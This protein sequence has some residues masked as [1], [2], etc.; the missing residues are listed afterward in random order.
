MK[1]FHARLHRTACPCLPTDHGEIITH[2]LVEELLDEEFVRL[3]RFDGDRF[4]DARDNFEEVALAQDFPSFLPLPVYA[5][6]LT[7]AREKASL[8]E[9]AAS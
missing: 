1:S 6:Y 8:E 3:E 4:E 2:E 7:E 9:L 5:R